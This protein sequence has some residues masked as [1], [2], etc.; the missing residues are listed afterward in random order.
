MKCGGTIRSLEM[1]P[2]RMVFKIARDS[3]NDLK[4]CNYNFITLI[5]FGLIY[6]R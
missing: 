1:Y 5:L 4:H 6:V 3:I 2:S